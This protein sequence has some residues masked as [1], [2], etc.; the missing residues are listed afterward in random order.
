MVQPIDFPALYHCKASIVCF[1]FSYCQHH[2][3]LVSL[4]RDEHAIRGI[5]TNKY[6]IKILFIR[7]HQSLLLFYE[8]WCTSSNGLE[9]AG[10]FSQPLAPFWTAKTSSHPRQTSSIQDFSNTRGNQTHKS[11]R[12]YVHSLAIILQYSSRSPLCT[13][14]RRAR[15]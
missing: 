4:A 10:D 9:H 2:D 6:I 12:L 13:P 14:R 8:S 5:H 11:C 1:F 7:N 3:L 15:D